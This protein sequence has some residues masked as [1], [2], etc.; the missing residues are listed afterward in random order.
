MFGV[1]NSYQKKK[2]SGP[3]SKYYLHIFINKADVHSL[4][5]NVV[6]AVQLQQIHFKWHL[7]DP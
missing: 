3:K 4:L 1:L 5:E 6:L 7:S 2:N